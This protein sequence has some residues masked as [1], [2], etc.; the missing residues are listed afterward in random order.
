MQRRQI[1]REQVEVR[2]LRDLTPVA[3]KYEK[4]FP[5]A[6]W[7]NCVL[8]GR[9]YA[10]PWDIGPC[11]VFYKRD[12]FKKH[13]IDPTRIET[14]D[15]YIAAGQEIL[16]K[17]HGRTKMLPL[18]PADMHTHFEMLLQQARGQYFDEQ[19]RVAIN[20]SAS[21][22]ALELMKRMRDAGICA[23]VPAWGHE[24][25]AGF[26][27]DTIATYPL[28][29]WLGGTIKDTTGQYG[30]SKAK[31]GVFNLPAMERGGPRVSNVGGSV[32]VIPDQCSNKEAAW[33]FVEYALCT[34][35]G[36][37]AQ[38]ANFD[39]FPAYLPALQDPFFQ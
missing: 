31:W 16:R 19:G 12:L 3:A 21:R 32:L 33:A 26:N 11:G 6:S 22:R 35:E 15:D 28:A 2:V 29:V 27:A 4:D 23:E 9:V 24:W 5:P 25:M 34:R 8:D 13:A 17:S 38:Y 30:D 7:A 14:W 1:R 18:A 36:Q 39:L 20:S 37:V 10:I